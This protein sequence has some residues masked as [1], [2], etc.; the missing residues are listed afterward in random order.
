MDGSET[1]MH[2][3]KGACHFNDNNNNPRYAPGRHDAGWMDSI[4]YEVKRF[5][6]PRKV[7]NNDGRFVS[8]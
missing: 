2:G 3:K 5:V 6:I 7:H 4:E 8:V 1:R